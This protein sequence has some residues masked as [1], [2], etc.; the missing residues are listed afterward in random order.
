M[1]DYPPPEFWLLHANPVD[2]QLV[3]IA[4]LQL[5]AATENLEIQKELDANALKHL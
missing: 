4:G 1:F 3:E 2:C 5:R